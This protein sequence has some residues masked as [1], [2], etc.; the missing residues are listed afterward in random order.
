[1]VLTHRLYVAPHLPNG[2]L[3]IDGNLDKPEWA[4]APWSTPFDEIRGQDDAPDGSRPTLA[5]RT[6]MKMLWDAEYLYI[7]AMIESDFQV[8][9]TFT[10]RNSPIHQQDSDFEVFIDADGSCHNY[11]ELEVSPTNVVWNLLLTR[12]YSDGGGERSG[13]VAQPGEP[14]YYEVE[15]QRTA[16]R[17]LNGRIGDASGATWTVEMA[18]AHRD[19][20]AR[21]PDARSPTAG[22]RWRINFSRVEHRGA[23]NWVWQPQVVWEPKARRYEGKVNMHLPDAWGF[24]EFAGAARAEC[25]TDLAAEPAQTLVEAEPAHAAAMSVYYAQHA[26]RAA[27]GSFARSIVELREEGLVDEAALAACTLSLTMRVADTDHGG[28]DGGARPT[29]FVVTATGDSGATIS[30]R[31]DRLVTRE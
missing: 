20:L 11:K 2:G 22:E 6:R 3:V 26:R 1:M 24:V 5:C 29:G 25:P 4:A 23:T 19:T 16:T 14:D 27:S 18:L 9:A 21:L 30:V 12:P 13:R 7:A 28:A 10:E 31:D 8:V 17:V 15:A